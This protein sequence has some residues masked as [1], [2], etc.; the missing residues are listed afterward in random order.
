MKT[1][2]PYYFRMTSPKNLDN[3]YVTHVSKTIYQNSYFIVIWLSTD[4]IE[5]VVSITKILST[6]HIRSVCMSVA[7]SVHILTIPS[8]PRLKV[9]T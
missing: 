7:L 2:M 1:Y 4:T 3:Q 6:C 9:V 8:P 5:C